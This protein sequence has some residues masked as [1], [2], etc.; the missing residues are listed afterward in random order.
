M[1]QTSEHSGS[2]WNLE[3]LVLGE[4]KT[5]VPGEK[6]LSTEKR[7]DNK[8]DPHD[9]AE[10][11]NQTLGHIGGGRVLSPLQHPCSPHHPCSCKSALDKSEV[12]TINAK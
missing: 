8:L 12:T 1:Y 4:G 10:S 6:P 11:G 3:V 7:T 9:N 5:G 2:N